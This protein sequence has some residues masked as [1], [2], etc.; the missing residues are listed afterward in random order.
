MSFFY[1]TFALLSLFLFL[2]LIAVAT[3]L[4]ISYFERPPYYFTNETGTPDGFLVEKTQKILRAA[5]LPPEAFIQIA[6]DEIPHRNYRYLMCSQTVS[7]ALIQRLN[8]A[9]TELS[10]EIE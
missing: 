4:T 6:L 8:T 1:N 3:P 5:G 10:P 9:I 7:D 2:P